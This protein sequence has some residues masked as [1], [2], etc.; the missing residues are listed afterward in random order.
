MAACF[1]LNSF[2]AIYEKLIHGVHRHD[3]PGRFASSRKLVA[4]ARAAFQWIERGNEF[5][6]AV[7]QKED[8]SDKYSEKKAALHSSL[9]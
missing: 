6:G 1:G 7:L 4:L 3:L 5:A 2:D 9:R 8:R